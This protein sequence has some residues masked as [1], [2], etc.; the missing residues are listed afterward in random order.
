MTESLKNILL[1]MANGG[2]LVRPGSDQEKASGTNRE[3]WDQTWKRLER[4]LPD[5]KNEL[6]PALPEVDKPEPEVTVVDLERA[7]NI[8]PPTPTTT[9]P[10]V[11]D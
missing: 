7:G 2:F 9:T 4:F 1:V 11:Q 8:T 5:L 10:P 6:F 3:L